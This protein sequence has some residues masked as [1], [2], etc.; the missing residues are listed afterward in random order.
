MYIPENLFSKKEGLKMTRNKRYL[1]V[2]L[3]SM[4]IIAFITGVAISGERVTI[5]GTVNDNYQIVTDDGNIYE[6]G[7]TKKGDEVVDLVDK[8][9]KVTGTVQESEG[10]TIINITS[11]EIIKE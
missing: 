9:V 4:I 2:G 5:T 7:D 10:E 3:C 11:Y 6:V 8:K 1:F